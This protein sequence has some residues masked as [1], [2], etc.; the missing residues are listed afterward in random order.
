MRTT[1]L[2]AALAAALLLGC[3]AK[4]P[5]V[6]EPSGRCEVDLAALGLLATT[7]EGAF[8]K[9]LAS[10]AEGIGGQVS[11]GDTGDVLLQ[12]DRVRVVIQRPGRSLAHIPY[13]GQLIDADLT[14]PSGERG[15]DQFGHLGMLYAFGRV[16]NAEKVE[17]LRDGYG[18]GSAVVAASGPDWVD[19]YASVQM[20]LDAIDLGVKLAVNP[21]NALPFRITTYYVLSPGESRVRILSAFCNTGSAPKQLAV[22]DILEEGGTVDFL[23]P[24]G[25]KKTPGNNDCLVDPARWFGYQGD[26]VAY[27]YR[28]Y[29]FDDLTQP[30]DSA[31][32]DLT[33]AVFSFAGG[34]DLQG[35]VSW[36]DAERRDRPGTFIVK[37]GEPSLFLRDFAIGRDLAEASGVFL[38]AD[39]AP[40]ANL[41]G[42]VTLADGSTRVPGARVAVLSASNE[43]VVNLVVADDQGRVIADLPPGDYRLSA[44]APGHLLEPVTAVTAVAGEPLVTFLKL[45]AARKLTVTVKDVGGGPLPAKVTVFCPV[46]CAGRNVAY[47]RFADLEALPSNVMAIGFVPPQG[48]LTLTVPPDPYELVVS[49]GPEYSVWPDTFPAKRA[50]VDLTAG[51]AEVNAVLGRVVDSAGW[52]SGDLHV[53]GVNSADSAA[54]NQ[55]RVLAYLAD[56]VDVLVSTDHDYVTDYAPYVREAGGDE[57][58]RTMIGGEVTPSFAHHNAFPLEVRSGPN[59][60]AFDWAGGEEP[61]LRMK[62]LYAGIR[63]SYPGALVQM[64][65]PRGTMGTL[66]RLKVDTATGASHADPLPLRMAAHPEATPD[67]ARLYSDDFDLFEVQNGTVASNTL[68]N[69]W[70]TFLSRGAIKTATAVTDTHY[71]YRDSAGHSRTYVRVEG[72]DTPA[73]L[74]L[75][76][77][78]A[79]LKAHRAVGSNGPFL[80]VTAR[81]VDAAG[82]PTGDA[83]EVGGTLSIAASAGEKVELTVDV[84]SPEWMGF[85]T[86]E[87]FTHADG[88]EAVNGV[89]NS[90]WPASRVHA[91]RKLE[92]ALIPLEQVPG[93]GTLRRRHAVERFTVAPAKDSWFVVVVRS[94]AAVATLFPVAYRGISCDS[95]GNCSAGSPRPYA[96]T[97]ALLV[98]A[99][100]SGAYDDFP[101][102]ATRARYVPP[103]TPAAKAPY[104]PTLE[105]AEQIARRLLHGDEP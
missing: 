28:S 7:G 76:S 34:Q 70:M 39:Q 87:L 36:V 91:S 64:N 55:T 30:D 68:L 47:G 57:L 79:G 104:V 86:I 78:V 20:S 72:P 71:T 48:T 32:L 24:T 82:N 22:G 40:R 33:H 41:V 99:D 49:R 50:Q 17:V 61:T 12:N 67:N 88:R 38:R 56:G 90:A 53:H 63:E 96:F 29:R 105:E 42:T 92:L 3:P 13:G 21:D 80:R 73:S 8:A 83:V 51:D 97:N 43:H 27:A 18:G 84:Q 74:S 59:G 98:D 10:K 9:P 100:G 26:G 52:A 77:F 66:T 6:E 60:G 23:N 31:L 44:G 54:A 58:L 5:P 101:L 93:P 85:D 65:H 11:V 45:G 102:K 4:P 2:A 75:P 35:L 89:D 62:E 37:P 94:S 103:P 25:C 95:S 14:R 15:R 16:V 46:S 19:D 1:P 69:D 81:R